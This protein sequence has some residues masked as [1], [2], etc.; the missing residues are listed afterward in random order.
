LNS[1]PHGLLALLHEGFHSAHPLL[2]RQLVGENEQQQ[3]ETSKA[4]HITI[5]QHALHV[6]SFIPDLGPMA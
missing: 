6:V 5:E 1:H 4:E 2:A 3:Q